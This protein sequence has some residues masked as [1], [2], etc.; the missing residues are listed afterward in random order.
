MSLEDKLRN[1][2]FDDG[3][4]NLTK[5]EYASHSALDEERREIYSSANLFDKTSDVIAV[6]YFDNERN[7]VEHI[8]CVEN[9]TVRPIISECAIMMEELSPTALVEYQYDMEGKWRLSRISLD[10]MVQYKAYKFKAWREMLDKPSCEAAFA[11]MIQCGLINRLY[12]KLGFPIPD[13]EKSQ[14]TVIDEKTGKEV[15]IPRPV[16]SL[17]I[18]NPSANAYD[19]ISPV[20]EGAPETDEQADSYWQHT[21]L[22]LKLF[23]GDE[24]VTSLLNR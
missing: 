4:G 22:E 17:R 12:D 11:R 2:E 7:V 23:H 3:M 14:W 20:M 1:L 16:Y 13:E 5:L 8:V 10:P 21:L 24:Y 9:D 19:Y 18:W 15:D 6:K